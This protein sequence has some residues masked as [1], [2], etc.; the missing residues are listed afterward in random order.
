[1]RV[2]AKGLALMLGLAVLALGFHA[3]DIGHGL[4]QAWVD[5]QVRGHGPYGVVLFL[6][7]AAALT[8]IGLP[9]QIIAFLG[10]YGFGA[11]TGTLWSV[12]GTLLGCLLS[13][14]YA[15]MGLA[16]LRG[17][18]GE[19]AARFDRVICR[20]PF[21]FTVLVR[22]LPVGNNLLTNLAA[23]LSGIR[24]LPF[25]LGSLVGYL[26]QTLAFALAGSGIRATP[27]VSLALGA[28]LFVVSG[29][30]GIWLYRRARPSHPVG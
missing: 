18:L 9:R 22:L 21:M 15:R 26:P 30:L 20:H 3:S 2:V 5:A 10:G 25:F 1:M 8:A 4:N 24:P 28:A 12:V 13:F 14:G 6:L 29:G 7:M 16:A 19:R 17:Q 23:G 11:A 27:V